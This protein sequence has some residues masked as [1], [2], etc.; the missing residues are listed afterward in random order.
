MPSPATPT[1]TRIV[2]AA[3]AELGSQ[4]RVVTIDDDLPVARQA[5]ALWDETLRLLLAEHPWNFA[6]R[7]AEL[8]ANAAAP[9]NGWNYGF[10]LPADCLRMLPGGPEFSDEWNRGEREGDTYYTDGEATLPVRYISSEAGGTVSRW[11]PHFVHAM[12]LMMAE[13]LAETV[14]QSEGIKD[15]LRERAAEA[16][17]R[18]KR[19]DGLETGYTERRQAT[20]RSDWLSGMFSPYN[21]FLR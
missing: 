2:N 17:R 13:R 1:Q 12:T 3:M 14:T 5:K 21:R 6:I 15:R 7:H 19:V 16:L 10:D 11:P 8:N 20:A 18:A 9:A 4:A